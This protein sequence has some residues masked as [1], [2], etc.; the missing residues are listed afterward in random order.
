MDLKD[1]I[2]FYADNIFVVGRIFQLLAPAQPTGGVWIH[3]NQ[4]GDAAS[5][6][7]SG[8]E[9][10]AVRDIGAFAQ[11]SYKPNGSVKIVAGWRIDN[12][13][14]SQGSAGSGF[15]TVFTPRLGIIYSP[16]GFVTKAIYSEAFKNP[17]SL[18]KFTTLP[19]VLARP[20]LPLKPERARN[21]EISVGR[22]WGRFAA[23]VAAYQTNYS[24]L[25]TLA[26]DPLANETEIQNILQGFGKI[27]QPQ[28]F[29]DYFFSSGIITAALPKI[30]D[31][32]VPDCR[33]DDLDCQRRSKPSLD[34][35]RKLF[36]DPLFVQKFENSGA[37]RVRGVEAN[38]SYSYG[39]TDLFANYTYASPIRTETTNEI[40]APDR[41]Q[42]ARLGDIAAHKLNLGVQ[43][44]WRQLDLSARMNAV[45]AR[46]TWQSN[47]LSDLP[48]YSVANVALSY[49][50]F[51]PGFTAQLV[52]NNIFS[53]SYADPGVRTADNIRFA[54]S[55]PQ[56][57]RSIFVKLLA[58]QMF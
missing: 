35:I 41:T 1:G 26:P 24:N 48:R 37:L 40:L 19:G 7:A 43:H 27:A 23:D 9:H 16:R 45:G 50:D 22:Q 29:T 46:P 38:A 3:C 18:E 2:K 6:P 11:G 15:G 33:L 13:H 47:P 34:L 8:G 21:F 52:I 4:T 58:R 10:F 12:D 49:V 44:R 54:S 28:N 51:L 39:S 17:S 25:V 31:R 36:A 5:L 32:L 57:G 42:S 55:I 56:P 30:I 20:D 53:A 14:V